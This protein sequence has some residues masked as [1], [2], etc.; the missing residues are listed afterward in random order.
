MYG[1]RL[2]GMLAGDF[3]RRNGDTIELTAKRSPYRSDVLRG[4]P[5]PAPGCRNCD[6]HIRIAEL[7]VV[8]A[9]FLVFVVRARSWL[10]L[11]PAQRAMA[12]RQLHRPR[13]AATL[14]AC[15]PC[16]CGAMWARRM[17]LSLLIAAL[18]S[19]CLFVL[20]TPA[21][22]TVLT[23]LSVATLIA[24]ASQR[25][26]YAGGEPVLRFASRRSCERRLCVLVGARLSRPRRW[27]FSLTPRGRAWRAHSHPSRDHGAW[28]RWVAAS[29]PGGGSGALA[30]HV[31]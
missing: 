11:R 8:A 12:C 7:A 20:Y 9:W 27:R 15:S 2:H 21:V 16:R 6:A 3:V 5:L 24:V 25:G 30:P 22:Y 18:T 1:K 4:S 29:V 14:S 28:G 17:L 23:S 10:S 26:P 31:H 13:C 19:A